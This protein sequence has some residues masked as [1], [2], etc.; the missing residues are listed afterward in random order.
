V[1][2]DTSANVLWVSD[3]RNH[4]VL[5]YGN[6]APSATLVLGQPDFV[7]NATATTQTGMNQPFGVSVDPTSGKIFVAEWGNHRVLRFASVTALSNG[8]AA[9]AVLGQADF[10]SNLPNRGGAVVANTMNAPLGVFV[11]SAGRLW[12]ADYFNNRV[13]RFDNAATKPDGAD[14]DGVLGQPDFVSNALATT[15]SGMWNPTDVFVDSSGRLWVTDFMNHRV[16]RFDNAASKAV[17]ADAN[18]VLGQLDFISRVAATSQNGMNG[19]AGLFVDSYGRLWVAEQNNRRVLRFDD[20]ASKADGAN[21]DGVLGQTNFTSIGF[22]CTQNRMSMPL[23]VS[24]DL[25]GRLYVADYSNNRV[26]I[27]DDAADLPNGANASDLLGQS[28]FSICTPN[29][30]GVSAAS[31]YG[32]SRVFFDRA[33]NVLWVADWHNHRLLMFGTPRF[34]IYLPVVKNGSP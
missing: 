15:Q 17:G 7:S 5:L 22:P 16:L 23:G 12:V 2:F 26:L 27:F 21:A 31:L 24:G 4:R 30:G 28:N 3:W 34:T 32:L 10:T 25:S 18:G 33:A 9:E 29:T 20:A 19:P 6:T 13:L 1:F 8:A 14:A 11:D